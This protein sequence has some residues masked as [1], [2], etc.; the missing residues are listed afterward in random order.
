MSKARATRSRRLGIRRHLCALGDGLPLI[1]T[2]VCDRLG[3]PISSPLCHLVLMHIM[4]RSTLLSAIFFLFSATLCLSA[5]AQ[6]DEDAPAKLRLGVLDVSAKT[7]L[8]KTVRP[9]VRSWLVA[10][11]NLQLVDTGPVRKTLKKQRITEVALRQKKLLTRKADR[12]SEA[13]STHDVQGFLLMNV[14]AKGSRTRLSFVTV[15]PKGEIIKETQHRYKTRSGVDEQKVHE[16]LDVTVSALYQDV[17]R[18]KSSVPQELEPLEE[19]DEEPLEQEQPEEEPEPEIEPT[20]MGISGALPA[21][22]SLEISAMGAYRNVEFETS[23]GSLFYSTPYF[24]ARAALTAG[25][26][27]GLLHVAGKLE[28]AYGIGSARVF[29]EDDA[30]L[31]IEGTMMQGQLGV[32]VGY[33]FD[34]K[35]AL[36]VNVDAQALSMLVEENTRYTGHR[37]IS[38][39]SLVGVHWSVD[40]AL[41]VSAQVG[42]QSVISALTSGDAYG[43]GTFAALGGAR[44]RIS[45]LY[46]LDS[47]IGVRLTYAP[48]WLFPEYDVETTTSDDVVHVVHLGAQVQF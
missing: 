14:E 23:T 42:H 7:N 2:P 34:E 12:I 29:D 13:M 3:D 26:N 27:K 40:E 25:I 4:R 16:M 28:G 33:A 44:A 38:I 24:G 15:G 47:S 46:D 8:S 19:P 37:Y 41:S 9:A 11:T 22:R 18:P 36:L 5:W 30:P 45:A 21:A 31:N 1:M 20:E 17:F 32:Q 6:E 43:T 39:A 35:F 10:Q 48:Q